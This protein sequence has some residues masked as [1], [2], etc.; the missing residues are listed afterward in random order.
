MAVQRIEK[1]AETRQVG[2]SIKRANRQ[3]YGMKST[4]LFTELAT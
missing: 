1:I 4:L 3:T 2:I